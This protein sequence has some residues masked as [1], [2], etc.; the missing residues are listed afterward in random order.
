MTTDAAPLYS[1]R[2]LGFRLASF[3]FSNLLCMYVQKSIA[4][5]SMFYRFYMVDGK[6][7]GTSS[8]AKA[9]RKL[10]P[11]PNGV[12]SRRK[13]STC[14][15]MYLRLRFARPCMH[16]RCLAM[17]CAHFGRD[18]ICTQADASFSVW[19]PNPS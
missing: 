7:A 10:K 14:V 16:L 6:S 19:S 15:Y 12:A 2:A 17:N 8:I 3:L 18:Q 4:L 13:F 1:F 11:W 9:I 5:G